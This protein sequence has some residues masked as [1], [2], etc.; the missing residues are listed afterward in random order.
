MF[1]VRFLAQNT[2][3]FFIINLFT[4]ALNA[5][6]VDIKLLQTIHT[7]Q[8]LPADNFWRGYSHS[9]IPLS[10][11]LPLGV[12]VA[13]LLEKDKEQSQKLRLKT[14]ELGVA[15]TLNAGLTYLSKKAVNRDRPFIAYPQDFSAKMNE[16]SASFPSGHTSVAFQTATSLALYSRKWYVIAPAYAWACG[17]GYS[18]MYLGVHYPSDVL[19]GAVLGVGSAW[20]T[21]RLHQFLEKKNYKIR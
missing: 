16:A 12:G 18:R 2:F 21:Y 6:S 9:V 3:V 14:L 5:Q 13:S 4:I 8:E 10:I 11:G 20:A 15:W 1:K 19:A 7:R 17:V